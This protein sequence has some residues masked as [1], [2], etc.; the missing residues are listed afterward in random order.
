MV[1]AGSWDMEGA[2]RGQNSAPVHRLLA[3]DREIFS[4]IARRNTNNLE[5]LIVYTSKVE[6]RRPRGRSPLRWSD[7]ITEELEMPMNVAMHQATG[8]NKWRHLVDKIR[9]DQ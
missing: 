8:R 4:H 6:G 5:R 3:K 1:F 9:S 2:A 7:Q